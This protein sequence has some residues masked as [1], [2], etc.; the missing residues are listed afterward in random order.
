M[1]GD[2]GR[3]SPEGPAQ[4]VREDGAW[5]EGGQG[6][7]HGASRRRVPP[8]PQPSPAL[9]EQGSRQSG[10]SQTPLPQARVLPSLRPAC[11]DQHP[12]T[13]GSRELRPS[14]SQ[15]LPGPLS[16]FQSLPEPPQG[17]VGGAFAPHFPCRDQPPW[18][19]T[20]TGPQ[21]GWGEGG[22][23]GGCVAG[24]AW[25]QPDTVAAQPVPPTPD[26]CPQPPPPR[27]PQP[28]P[29]VEAGA[30]GGGGKCGPA[31]PGAGVERPLG[32]RGQHAWN[33]WRV[34]AARRGGHRDTPSAC[35]VPNARLP[36]LYSRDNR[37]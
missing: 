13:T 29:D 5:G 18:A 2:P 11:R 36:R 12:G 19:P 10:T 34:T 32:Q 31:R 4:H 37:L 23:E 8:S 16:T 35:L 25:T 6:T 21:G 27:L 24:P 33:R 26:S 9:Q 15:G 3:H 30:W 20:G 14:S 17:D 7:W 28:H 1:C 22:T